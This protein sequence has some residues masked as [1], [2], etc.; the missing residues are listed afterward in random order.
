[1]LNSMLKV[2]S[3]GSDALTLDCLISGMPLSAA[4]EIHRAIKLLSGNVSDVFIAKQNLS[5]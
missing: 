3:A 5:T 1:M 4:N 2:A